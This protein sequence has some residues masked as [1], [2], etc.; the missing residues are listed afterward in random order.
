[1]LRATVAL[2]VLMLLASG[3]E[4][5][6]RVALVIGNGDYG[7]VGKLPNPT[8]DAS[9]VEAMLRAAGF[10]AVEVKRDLGAIALRRALRDLSDQ[11]RGADIAVVFFAGH[12]IE[13]NGTNYLIPVDATLERDIDVEDEAVPLERVT[14]VLEQAK[15]LRLVILDAC[16][17]NPFVRSMRRTTAGRSI[18]RGLAKVEVL[19]S[20][21]LIA[22]AAKA[23][24]TALDGDGANSPYT[25]ALVKH[26]TTPGLDLRLALGRVRDEVL[27]NTN[28]KQEPFVYGSLGG[29][30]IALVA[31]PAAPPPAPAPAPT[32]TYSAAAEGAR[33]C[34]EVEG[35]SSL[36]ML[37]VLANQHKGTPSGDC[38]VARIDELKKQVALAP[39]TKTPSLQA[40]PPM[41]TPALSETPPLK[42]EVKQEPKG[43]P[44]N[45]IGSW[46]CH[47][48]TQ[49]NSAQE[50]VIVLCRLRMRIDRYDGKYYWVEF[51][52][53]DG[54]EGPSRVTVAKSKLWVEAERLL[55]QMYWV[56][57]GSP[58]KVAHISLRSGQLTWT[59]NFSTGIHSFRCSR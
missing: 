26:L 41:P 30:E 6:K 29:A 54:P 33:V 4:A 18:G 43:D 31:A 7:K 39:V 34:R 35:M 36:S 32:P 53:C 44:K 21:T 38:I 55:M 45:L 58:L 51:P 20:D 27:R 23:G 37:G 10:D 22:F 24:S 9:S 13:V 57:T 19:T 59:N 17:D 47:R 3:A 46:N 40:P 12:G 15:R 50:K 49:V 8:R 14:Q 2:L 25:V 42:P 56:S 28:S 52:T 1:M 16:R 11:V 5:Q 48:T